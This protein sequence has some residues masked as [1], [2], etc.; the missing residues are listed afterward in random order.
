MDANSDS[1]DFRWTNDRHLHFL[2]SVEA[3]FVRTILEHGGGR[4]LLLRMDRYLP[5]S[6]ESTL[7][8]KTTI[9][10]KRRKRHFPSARL[11]SLHMRIRKIIWTRAKESEDYAFTNSFLLLKTIRQQR[12]SANCLD[13]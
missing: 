6:C 11:R 7:D 2:K 1:N 9:C 13:I 10:T 8:S 3:S 5:D 4:R 12:V